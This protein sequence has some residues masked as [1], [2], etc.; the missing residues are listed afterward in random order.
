MTY[1]SKQPRRPEHS[2]S[3]KYLRATVLLEKFIILR[4]IRYI[5]DFCAVPKII[6]LFTGSHCDICAKSILTLF[7]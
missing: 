2:N 6:A 3:K 1:D 5:R 7:L 4:V